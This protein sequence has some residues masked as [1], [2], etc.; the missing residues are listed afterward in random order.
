MMYYKY[1]FHFAF[2]IFIVYWFYYFSYTWF[3]E[4]ATSVYNANEKM[5]NSSLLLRN[6]IM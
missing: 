2:S 1:L 6:W 3:Y 4:Y 5:Y